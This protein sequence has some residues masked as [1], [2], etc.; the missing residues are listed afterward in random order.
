MEAG[1]DAE[2]KVV[3][4]QLSARSIVKERGTGLHWQDDKGKP[5]TTSLRSFETTISRLRKKLR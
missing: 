3:V 2:F 1:I 5:K 4:A